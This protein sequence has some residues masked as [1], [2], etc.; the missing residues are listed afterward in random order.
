MVE[1]QARSHVPIATMPLI[2]RIRCRLD[3]PTSVRKLKRSLSAGIKL[4]G[5]RNRVL[6]KF[7]NGIEEAVYA[8]FPVVVAAMPGEIGAQVA[9]PIAATLRNNHRGRG[10]IRTQSRAGVA[11]TA[12]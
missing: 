6:Q 11:H 2:L 1:A 4:R 9:F 12:G 5:I 10:W 3:V 8:G 7:V